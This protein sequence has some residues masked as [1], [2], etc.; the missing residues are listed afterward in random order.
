MSSSADQV[1]IYDWLNMKNNR[2]LWND[3]TA[4]GRGSWLWISTEIRQSWFRLLWLATARHPCPQSTVTCTF[5]SVS[6]V[7]AR[8]VHSV[9]TALTRVSLQ[10]AAAAPASYALE[11]YHILG[12]G[13]FCTARP[14][15]PWYY[16]E[17]RVPRRGH[18]TKTDSCIYVTT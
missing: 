14:V 3:W 15:T 8:H 6:P 2:S 13:T 5:S 4:F 1:I 12:S 11:R 17:P 18:S 16:W 7:C 10:P 9:W